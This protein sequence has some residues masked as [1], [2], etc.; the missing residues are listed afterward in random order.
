MPP[1]D[2]GGGFLRSKKTEGEKTKDYPSV[3]CRRQPPFAVPEI[4][5]STAAPA[6][7]PSDRE[8]SVLKPSFPLNHNKKIQQCVSI[9]VFF[10]VAPKRKIC[11]SKL[12]LHPKREQF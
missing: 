8:E 12:L 7:A 2:E 3:G 9:A 5:I 11:V 10:V 4:K 1:S 6:R